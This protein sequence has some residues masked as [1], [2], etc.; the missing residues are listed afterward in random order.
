MRHKKLTAILLC[1]TIIFAFTA[2]G[3]TEINLLGIRQKVAKTSPKEVTLD[4]FAPEEALAPVL[5]A[6]EYYKGVDP[7]V[8]VRLTVDDGVMIA[9]KVLSGYS[10]D[11]LIDFSFIMDQIDASKGQDLNPVGY[12]CIYSDT[13]RD[14]FEGP[15][16]KELLGED[17]D[18][19]TLVYSAALT[20]SCKHSDQ[21][22][23]FID[24]LLSDS[25]QT[26]YAQCQCTGIQ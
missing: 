22:K 21:A 7:N 19:E 2:C 6:V 4:I 26:I 23:G 15:A 17:S 5:T 18:V 3:Q 12:D 9:E 10:C 11:V 1:L 24:Y 25:A 16:D 14:V 8:T 20:R 13:R